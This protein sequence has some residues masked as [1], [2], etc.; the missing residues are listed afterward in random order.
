MESIKAVIIDDQ[1][2]QRKLLEAYSNKSGKITVLGSFEGV[3]PW[4]SSN[5]DED[6]D[7]LFLD[8]E[9]PKTSGMEFLQSS[10]DL[11]QVILVTN[12]RHFAV[13]A[14]EFEVTDYMVKPYTYSRF[15]S[16]V[17]K[18]ERK[19]NPKTE[20]QENHKSGSNSLFV[21]VGSRL[22]KIKVSE[23]SHLESLKDQVKVYF[24]DGSVK[25]VSTTLKALYE[26]L[27]SKEFLLVH[28]Q[29]IVCIECIDE[30]LT[31]DLRIKDQFIPIS[32]RRKQI[33]LEQL[34][35]IQ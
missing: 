32:R 29:H 9:M 11:P 31:S 13:E 22:I 23:I 6:P 7:L 18:V 34:R 4:L 21:K 20:K 8:V 30:I 33:V 1:A 26:E 25:K 12:H 14:F 27:P 16:A 3:E 28:R 17:A 19:I 15:L 35:F 10:P 5:L 24:R 2:V